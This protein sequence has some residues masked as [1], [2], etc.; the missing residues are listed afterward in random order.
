MKTLVSLIKA[1]AFGGIMFLRPLVL[2]VGREKLFRTLQ[3]YSEKFNPEFWRLRY[4]KK[5]LQLQCAA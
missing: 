3:S 4:G 5:R 2:L 1:I